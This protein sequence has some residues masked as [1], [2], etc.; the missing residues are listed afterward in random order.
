MFGKSVKSI[1]GNLKAT[2]HKLLYKGGFIRELVAGRYEML[3]LGF[4]VLEKIINIIEEEMQAIGSQRVVTPTLHPKEIWQKTGRDEVWGNDLLSISDERTGQEFTLSATAEGLFT[5]MVRDMGPSYRDLPILI[6]QFSQKFRNEKRPRGGLLRLR[7]F[8]MKDAYSFDTGAEAFKETYY[9]FYKAYEKVA[10]RLGLEAIPVEAD[11]GALGGEYS[12]EFMIPADFG[13]D[14]IVRCNKC[15]Y[16]A[17]IEKAEFKREEVNMDE[18]EKKMEMVDLPTEVA[19]IPQLT[20]HYNLSA[21]RFIKNV[22][23]KTVD[24]KIIIATVTG[25]LNVN[26]IKLQRALGIDT[27]LENANDEDLE[28]FGSKSGFVHSWGYEDDRITYVADTSIPMSRNLFGGYKTE[29]QDPVNVNYGRDF[30]SNIVADIAEAYDGAECEKCKGGTLIEIRAIEFGHVFQYGDFYS[31]HHDGYYIDSK[32]QKQL[33]YMGAYGI[34]I[35]RAIATIVETHNDDKGIIWPAS[36]APY[37]VHLISLGKGK[38]EA[39]KIASNVYGELIEAGV[40]VLWDDRT[41]VRAGEKFAD[42]DLIGIP[43]RLVVSE[44]SLGAGGVEVKR[45]SEAETRIVDMNEVKEV[46]TYSA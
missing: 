18:E 7:E 9:K 46:V 25:N 34:G 26:V 17:N 23:Y 13:E 43:L 39:D 35:E 11:N 22:V 19:T 1:P 28:S 10:E 40:E 45:R 16:A 21:N 3:P 44:K 20:K 36:I 5:E 12:H 31:K 8:I 42:A 2:S 29:T 4:R 15:G 37:A 41:E 6:H 24:G 33:L 14:K 30:E 32:D 38:D 27:D